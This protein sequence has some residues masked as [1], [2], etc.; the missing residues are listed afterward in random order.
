[1]K[2]IGIIGGLGPESTVEYYKYVVAFHRE[3]TGHYPALIVNSIDLDRMIEL[4]SG[5]RLAD[6]AQYLT[7][8]LGRLVRAGAEIGLIGANMP[9]IVFDDVERASPIP[10]VSIVQATIAAAQAAGMRR[11]GL[12][13]ARFTMQG[14]F[15]QKACEK[16]GITLIV[17]DPEELAFVGEKYLGELVRGVFL[18][19]TYDGFVAI[20]RRL[21]H[22][23]AIDGL[24][25]GGTE[26]PLLLKDERDVGVR[27]LDT[28][29]IHARAIVARALE[30]DR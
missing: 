27:L 22:R 3:E 2:T 5:N 1:M 11:L 17:P 28:T 8:E 7:D 23:N 29:R 13:G 21:R 20:A 24:I 26:L 6:A 19:E 9:H 12:F 30:H 25:L 10:L 15:Y 14:G 16:A 4:V 18:P